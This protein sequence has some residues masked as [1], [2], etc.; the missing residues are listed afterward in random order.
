MPNCIRLI[1]GWLHA[2][3][4]RKSIGSLFIDLKEPF[5]LV[6]HILLHKLKL[7]HF[8]DSSILLFE[9]YLKNRTQSVKLGNEIYSQLSVS[10]GIPQGSILGPL[11]F[12]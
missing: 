8:T 9:S 3:D 5:D 7:Y 12:F 2:I 6:D 11:L 4:D 1:D 10:S